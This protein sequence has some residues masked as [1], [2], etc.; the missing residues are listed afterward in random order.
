M[1]KSNFIVRL[2]IWVIKTIW[3]GK[4][5]R[6][7]NAK[8]HIICRFY[9]S[10]SNYAIMALEKYGFFKGW[11]LAVTRIIRCTPNNTESCIDYP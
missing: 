4:V 1:Q 11:G 7:Y 6:N 2:S 3:H 8:R 10:C 9:P 5:G